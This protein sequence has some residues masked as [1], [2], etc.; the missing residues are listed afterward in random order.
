MT[1]PESPLLS[2]AV[3]IPFFNESG[4]IGPTL[5]RVRAAVAGLGADRVRIYCV[6]DG[7]VD[8]GAGEAR[9]EGVVLVQHPT[10]RG[11]GAALQSGIARTTEDLILIVD[12]DGTYPV[13]DIPRLLDA[14]GDDVDMVVGSRYGAGLKQHPMRRLGRWILG[15]MVHALTGKR[16]PDLNSGLR[17]FRRGLYDEFQ[18]LLPQGFSFTTTITVASL[19]NDRPMRYL[20]VEYA[21]REGASHI[22]ALRDF[23]GFGVLILRL[24]KYFRRHPTPRGSRTSETPR[25]AWAA[26][27]EAPRDRA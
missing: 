8:G 22:R 4:R 17:V 24:A 23:V 19:F 7:S 18:H 9:V 13:E 14:M 27:G 2:C 12:G 21:R 5:Q 26:P 20:P 6:D 3:V 10:N 1:A 15:G 11:Y 25:P 16:V